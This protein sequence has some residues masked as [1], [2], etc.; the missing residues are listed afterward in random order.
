MPTIESNSY[1]PFLLIQKQFQKALSS[2][3]E[4]AFAIDERRTGDEYVR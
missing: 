3:Y 1:N 4:I 2:L